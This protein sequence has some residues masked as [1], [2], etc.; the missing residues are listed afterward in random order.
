MLIQ[1]IQHALN[2]KRASMPQAETVSST[3]L[4]M[5]LDYAIGVTALH[6]LESGQAPLDFHGAASSSAV[7]PPST[8]PVPGTPASSAHHGL[9]T[10]GG[11]SQAEHLEDL[12]TNLVNFGKF[13]GQ[14]FYKAWCDRSYV[15]WALEEEE[16]VKRSGKSIGSGLKQL[17][18]YFREMQRRPSPAPSVSGFMAVQDS[19]GSENDLIAILD[20]GC[21]ATC[22][23]SQWYERFVQATG[24]PN[25]SLDTC[26]GSNMKGIGGNMRVTGKRV[27]EVCFELTCGTFARGTL[28]SLE[29]AQSQAPLLLSLETQRQLGF[30]IDIANNN[31]FS[32]TL[33]SNLKLVQRDG[34]LAIRL[35]PSYIGLKCTIDDDGNT[36]YETSFEEPGEH[37]LH[38][39]QGDQ[40]HSTQALHNDAEDDELPLTP[41]VHLAVDE[42]PKTTLTKGQKRQLAQ[43]IHEVK[44][45]DNH[46][47]SCLR[48]SKH[49]SRQP[50]VLPRG[51][52]TFLLEIFAGAAL[53][54]MLATDFGLPVSQPV[55]VTHDGINLKWKQHRDL[56]DQQIE[57]DD[58]YCISLSPTCG[59]WSPWQYVNLAK[60]PSFEMKLHEIRRECRPVVQWMVQLIR[61][62]LAKGRQIIFEQPWPSKMWDLLSMQRLL[63]DAPCDAATGEHLEAVRCDQ[64]MFGLKDVVN[65]LPHKKPTGIMTASAGVKEFIGIQCSGDHQHQQLEGSNR[66][67]RAQE[68]PMEFCKAMISGLLRDLE[69]N[70]TK[71]AFPAEAVVEDNPLGSLDKIYDESDLAPPGLHQHR[72]DDKELKGEE[73]RQERDEALA[74][75]DAIRKQE[76]LRLPY[77]QRVAVRRLHQMTGHASTSA[78]SRMLRVAKAAPE[79][80]QRLRYFKCEACLQDQKPKPRP[81]VRPPNPYVFNYEVTADVFECRDSLG[82]RY[83]VLSVICMG[84]LYHA[85][86]VVSEGGGTPSSLRCAEVVR[87]GWL[88]F[89]PPRYMTVD[90][91]VHNRG[92][93]AALMSSQ[94]TYLRYAETEAHYQIGRA[95]RQG[96][97]LKEMIAHTVQGRHVVGSQMMKMVVSE[98][99]F[100]KNNRINHGGFSPSQWVLGRLPEEVCSLTAERAEGDLGVH[101]EIL[102]GEHQFAQQLNIRQAAKE[103]FAHV[104]SSNRIRTA[105]MRRSTPCRG[106][107]FPGDL[108]CFYRNNKWFGPA[109]MIGREGR[110]N[111][112]L[113]H[114]G[115]PIVISEES[116]R[117]AL[118]G[119]VIAKQITE[120]KPSRKRK[121]Q[122]TQDVDHELPFL[123]DLD[124]L[125]GNDGDEDGSGGGP[126]SYFHLGRGGGEANV[127]PSPGPM[128]VSD[129]HAAA[130]TA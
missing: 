100:V 70:M 91:G 58:P 90:R 95:E 99:A 37:Q 85:A 110:S 122:I 61:K 53:L 88:Q 96:S 64:C 113:I 130:S 82:N 75:E 129:D 43:T 112:W 11:Q 94:G 46:L 126:G 68:W 40:D 57:K 104:D 123:D 59:P 17:C 109:R 3:E 23:G 80:I 2:A 67:H 102:T 79:V 105:L 56:I 52:R 98:C 83:S 48:A 89:G 84:T 28:P 16:N 36:R 45:K 15:D 60:D 119:E 50:R 10:P 1:V 86:W 120:L 7:T 19:C 73:D 12:G 111:L 4:H 34:L 8:T 124:F 72:T 27:L 81:V 118:A 106:P 49:L 74:E 51:C 30:Q 35:I 66:T 33:Q 69:L 125:D 18:H 32:T 103:S 117:P 65:K 26:A 62:R 5:L 127:P 92:Q 41:E 9:H 101:Q 24:C 55:D 93:F 29:L 108:L 44:D 38:Q 22:H 76:W 6:E 116:V 77:S 71:L 107:C 25:V 20:T 54:S 39:Q 21:N 31:V 97:I 87:D 78:M 14:T 13:K 121:R 115:I 47:W 42:L 63:H 114:G 128:N